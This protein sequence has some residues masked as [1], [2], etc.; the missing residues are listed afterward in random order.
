MEKQ[1]L[2]QTANSVFERY[3]KVNKVFVTTDGQ[4]FFE[5]A[6]AETHASQKELEV[7]AVRREGEEL[8]SVEL[9]EMDRTQLEAFIEDNELKVK[10]NEKMTDENLRKAI[11]GVLSSKAKKAKK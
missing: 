4:V 2:K 7:V 3:P 9:N 5:E 1:D 11:A 10:V 8:P 6:Y